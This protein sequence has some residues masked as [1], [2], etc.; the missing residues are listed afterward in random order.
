MQQVPNLPSTPIDIDALEGELTTHPDQVFAATLVRNLRE[1]FCIGYAGPEFSLESRNLISAYEHPDIVSAYL[2]KE[3]VLGRISGP[4]PIPPFPNFRC[5]PLGVVPKKTPGQWRSILHLS[6][7][8]GESV[9]D[10]IDKDTY[11]LQYVTIERVIHH[12]RRLGPGCFLSKVD[13]EAAF[14]IASVHP[15]DWHLLGMKWNGQYYFDMRLS[16]GSRFSPHNF[17]TIGQAVEFICRVN[18]LVKIIEHLLDDFIT[19]EPSDSPPIALQ[20]IKFVFQKLGIPLAE[21]KVFGPTTC[22]DFLGITLD[23]LLIE[24]RLPQ[25]KVEKLR[26]LIASF[27][28]RKKCTKRELLSLIGSFSFACKVIVLGR[29]FLSRMV[30][31]SCTVK[32]LHYHVYLTQAFRE[33]LTMWGLFLRSWNGRTFFLEDELTQAPDINFYTDA[34]GTSGYGGYYHP[35]WFRGAW[36]PCQLLCNKGISIAYQ[37]LFPI[38]LAALLWGAHW[39]RKHILVLCD[40]EGTVTVI[41]SGTS[42]SPV[43]ANLLRHLVLCSMQCNFLVRAKHLPGRNNPIAD[44]LSCNQVQRFRRLAPNAHLLPT[45]IPE[46]LL[47]K[48]RP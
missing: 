45:P 48:L 10:F 18:Y 34:S 16:M 28:T 30:R 8:P 22:L 19:V 37:E 24:A 47:T 7:P 21:D 3:I 41:N 15:N 9:N 29:T 36:E 17:D 31:L 32:E 39:S 4:Y 1:G 35:E 42:K 2:D 14:R 13:I 33:D 38:V 40:N 25:D 11:S 26:A 5:N 27:T 43:M 46:E 44:A 6:Y 12:I 23:T 20:V